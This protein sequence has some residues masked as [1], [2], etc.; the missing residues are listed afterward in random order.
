MRS[1]A[2]PPKRTFYGAGDDLKRSFSI[3]DTRDGYLIN[4]QPVPSPSLAMR[5]LPVQYE[6]GIAFGTAKLIGL[7][8]DTAGAMKKKYPKTQMVLGNLGLREGGDIPYSVSHNSGRDA[9][10]G[11]Y[12]TDAEGNYAQLDNLYK[13]NRH[14]KT[15]GTNSVYS[16]DIEKNAT[17]VE[18]LLMH[19][20]I[21]IQFIFVAKH[22]RSALLRELIARNGADAPH[23]NPDIIERFE[24]SVQNQSAHDDHF[25]IRIYCSDEDLCAG[26][27]DR[28]VIHPWH[29]DPA[30]KIEQ[31]V[32]EHVAAL[33]SKKT[34]PA[35][36]ADAVLRLALMDKADSGR[37]LILA[38]LR[39]EDDIVR[40]SAA[41]A[42]QKL[43][44]SALPALTAQFAAETNDAVRFALLKTIAAIPSD[45][46]RK[47]IHGELNSENIAENANNIPI[48]ADY[49]AH[50]PDKSDLLPLAAA[51]QKIPPGDGFDMLVEAIEAVAAQPFR[52][53]DPADARRRIQTWI[54]QN[55]E[56]SR[57]TWLLDG[58][59]AAGYRVDDFSAANIPKLLDAIDGPR[60]I[61][62]NAQLMLKSIAKLPQD[63]L[64]WPVS[65]ARW[66]YTRYF[67]RRAKK[68]RIDLSDRDERGIKF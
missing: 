25:H 34:S 58:F 24:Q 35:Q 9:D 22:L 43:G 40:E 33:K 6:R 1:P 39:C 27:V 19:P 48:L 4:G 10:I 8:A 47:I 66:H 46:S 11:F 29:E 3:G 23:P 28:S 2:D 53:E 44:K 32:R 21:R 54:A 30:P 37:D 18:T 26:C 20:T 55:G 14:F 16:F 12:L 64:S 67:K 13:I 42:A 38:S 5:Q 15:V 68:Y 61:S 31:C 7:L 49:I 51:I 57:Q 41:S 50:R 36:K 60:A 17:L 52:S 45:E 56:K 65:D 59:A 62:I 63:S